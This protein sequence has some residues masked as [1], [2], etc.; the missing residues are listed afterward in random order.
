VNANSASAKNKEVAANRAAAVSKVND[1]S[2]Y[3]GLTSGGRRLPLLF[4]S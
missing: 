2:G 3:P 1:S 4:M